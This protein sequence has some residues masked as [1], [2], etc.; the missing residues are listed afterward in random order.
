[1]YGDSSSSALFPSTLFSTFFV[2]PRNHLSTDFCLFRLDPPALSN[3]II[4]TTT[5]TTTATTIIII[6]RLHVVALS[7]SS[8][9][10]I[11]CL[12]LYLRIVVVFV[13]SF[14]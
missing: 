12:I 13:V 7:L 11:I 6:L 8:S 9:H 2:L 3:T 5:T 14:F 10:A 4:T 1:L